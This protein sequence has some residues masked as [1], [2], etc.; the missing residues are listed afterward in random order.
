MG[1][2]HKTR[3]FV[4]KGARKIDSQGV[5]RS[6]TPG[7]SGLCQWPAYVNGPGQVAQW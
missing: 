6:G 1:F 7:T 5:P 3:T 2:A 4:E